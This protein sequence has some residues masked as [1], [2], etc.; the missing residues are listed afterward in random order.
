MTSSGT[1]SL[2]IGTA[3]TSSRSS[4][5]SGV[6]RLHDLV[7]D[8]VV[9]EDVLDVV[10]ILQR[11]QQTEDLAGSVAVELDLHAGQERRLRG[12]VVHARRLQRRPYCDQVAG[13]GDDLEG[14]A[15]V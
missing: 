9:G 3:W 7:G 12:V 15:E 5:G 2:A 14:L 10:E 1:S 13:L 8:V 4:S 6:E 11:L